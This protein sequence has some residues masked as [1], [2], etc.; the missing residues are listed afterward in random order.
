MLIRL[1]DKIASHAE[2]SSV[3]GGGGGRNGVEASRASSPSVQASPFHATGS[4]TPRRPT[5][6]PLRRCVQDDPRFFVT[7]PDKEGIFG[8]FLRKPDARP[9]LWRISASVAGAR[10]LLAKADWAGLVS[11]YGCQ[12]NTDG[13]PSFSPR[14]ARRRSA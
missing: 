2:R 7:Q 1:R 13:V 11:K 5:T 4:F 14:L 6:F 12:P 3:T 10:G 9:R 8:V